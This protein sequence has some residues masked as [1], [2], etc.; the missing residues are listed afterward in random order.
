MATETW[1]A[2]SPQGFLKKVA[3][4]FVQH[5]A[6]FYTTGEIPERLREQPELM[7]ERIVQK[8]RIDYSRFTRYRRKERNL[9]NAHYLRHK[10]FWVLMVTKGRWAEQELSPH[11][12]NEL[13]DIERTPLKFWGHSISSVHS[14][15]DNKRHAIV[16]IE[17][18]EFLGL[19]AFFTNQAWRWPV[20]LRWTGIQD[21][22]PPRL[23]R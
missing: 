17:R 20:Q 6:R 4:G 11:E 9:G 2:T 14:T 12:V 3:Q 7:D 16:R 8:Y 19:R 10:E 22:A 13:Q 5:G 1:E 23:W 18:Q 21:R 15:G